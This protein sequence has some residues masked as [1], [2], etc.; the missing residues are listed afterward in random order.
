[1]QPQRFIGM[2]TSLV[3]ITSN[4]ALTMVRDVMGP[5]VGPSQLAIE[6]KGG[7]DLIQWAIHMA[8]EANPRLV[9]DSVDAINAYGGIERL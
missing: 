2:G 4:C 3:K 1:M 5:A 7:C 8:Q 6:T 9:A